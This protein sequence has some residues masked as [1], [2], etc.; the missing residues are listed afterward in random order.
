MIR[1]PR[2]K[3]DVA[4]RERVAGRQ[5]RFVFNDLEAERERPTPLKP[6][7]LRELGKGLGDSARA[8]QGAERV[9]DRERAVVQPLKAPLERGPQLLH[10]LCPIR[11][12]RGERAERKQLGV[13][14]LTTARRAKPERIVDRPRWT[15]IGRTCLADQTSRRTTTETGTTA[16]NRCSWRSRGTT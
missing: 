4:D 1:I 5:P 16:V 8:S 9:C 6:G 14:H 7:S 15:G 13:L 12:L 2:L 3:L 11:S 10:R